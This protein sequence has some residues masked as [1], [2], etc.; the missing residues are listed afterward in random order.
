MNLFKDHSKTNALMALIVFAI[1]LI[2]YILT[3][4]P[5]VCLWDCGE[6]LAASAGLGLPHPPGTPLL[7]LFGRAWIVLLSFIHDIGY[8]YNLA[9]AVGSALTVMFIYMIVVRGL[10][11]V[12]GE[13]DTLWKRLV[14]YCGGFVGALFCAFGNTFWFESLESSEQSNITNVPVALSMWLT[15]VWAQSKSENRDRLLLLI[16]YVAFLCIGM[17]MISMITMPAIFLFVMVYDK[18]KRSDWRLWGTSIAL[19]LIMYNLSYFLIVAP[20]VTLIA[21]VMMLIP[22]KFQRNWR[23]CFWFCLLALLGFSNHL[24]LPIRA[25]LNPIIDEGHPV[26]KLAKDFPFV[27]MKPLKEVL[28]RKQYGSESMVSR[29][30]WRRGSIEHQFGV[31]GHMGYGGFHL[32]QFFRFTTKDAEKNFV[33]GSALGF[34]KL[35]LYLLPTIFIL[36]GWYLMGRRNKNVALFFITLTVLTTLLMVWYMN[37]SDGAH[38]DNRAEYNQWVQ[39]DHQGPMPTIYRE[40]RVRDYFYSAGFMCL[41]MW[42]GLSAGLVLFSLFS[43][44]DRTVR[45]LVAPCL[46]IL[47]MVSPALPLSQNYKLRDRS[48]NWI[49]FEYAYNLLM[50]CEKDGVLFTNGDNDTFPVWAV[51]EAYGIRPDVRLVNLSL[52]NTEWYVKQL[53]KLEPKVAISFKEEEIDH[54]QPQLNPF[55]TTTPYPMDSCGITAA[56]P[57]RQQLQV[58][59]VQDIMVLNIV[60]SNRWKKPIYFACSVSPDNFMGLEPYLQMQGMVYRLMKQPVSANDRVDLKRMSMLVDSVYKLRPMPPRVTDRDEPYEGIA[61]DY[62]ICFMWLAMHLQDRMTAIDHDIKEIQ[63]QVAAAPAVTP[64]KHAPAPA[65][66]D[67]SSLVTLRAQFNADLNQAVKGLDKCISL[68]PWN[69]QPIM[70]RQQMLMKFEKAAMAEERARKLVAADPNNFQLRDML[71]QTLEA[72]GKRKEAQELLQG[73]PMTVGNE[74]GR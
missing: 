52:V 30:L 54:L 27:D 36:L 29:S 5:S 46:L 15:L 47:F 1:S 4:A 61:N 2:V 56:I 66:P 12:L 18:E 22:D 59:R 69:M 40:V 51:Q 31:E 39:H 65:Q 60:E 53:K 63:K 26:V 71:A 32:T 23:F 6:Y 10:I 67:T 43:N 21:L 57:G 33:D 8:R 45:G 7:I 13:P 44:K 16:A 17:H 37:F 24:Y 62:A 48:D 19:G 11:M 42:M 28:D 70:L 55:D 25:S 68:M 41:G 50:S 9:S 34:A 14:L 73:M 72:Q 49:P 74:S 64:K 20:I 3:M 58:L 35:A 38:C